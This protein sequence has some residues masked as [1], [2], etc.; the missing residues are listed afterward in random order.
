MAASMM[1]RTMIHVTAPDTTPIDVAKADIRDV[2]TLGD[3][4]IVFM[5]AGPPVRTIQSAN[6]IIALWKS[7]I[8]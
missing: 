4:A 6:W 2:Q 5:K 1:Q 7:S 8:V 3:G